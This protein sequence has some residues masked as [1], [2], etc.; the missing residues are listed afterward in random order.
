M[1]K[2]SSTYDMLPV[3]FDKAAASGEVSQACMQAGMQAGKHSRKPWAATSDSGRHTQRERERERERKTDSNWEAS[4]P[5]LPR[6]PTTRAFKLIK[7]T[8]HR[9]TGGGWAGPEPVKSHNLHLAKRA[10]SLVAGK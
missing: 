1:R 5:V 7:I 3:L 10:A 9:R 2:D 6:M 4:E 8:G